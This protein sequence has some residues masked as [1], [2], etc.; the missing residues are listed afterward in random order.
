VDGNEWTA[1]RQ[2]K[3]AKVIEGGT[4]GPT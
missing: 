1:V 4:I 2:G 3:T